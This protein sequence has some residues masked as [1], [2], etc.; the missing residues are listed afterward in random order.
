MK[1]NHSPGNTALRVGLVLITVSLFGALFSGTYQA[2]DF[3][4]MSGMFYMVNGMADASVLSNVLG[5]A[6]GFVFP[7]LTL[8]ALL[9]S[10]ITK[11]SGALL[12]IAAFSVLAGHL[13]YAVSQLLPGAYF[14][15]ANWLHLLLGPYSLTDPM[16]VNAPAIIERLSGYVGMVG[17]VVVLV[18][19]LISQS[20]RK[21]RVQDL[22]PVTSGSAGIT[23][24][25]T[26][27]GQPIYGNAPT[28]N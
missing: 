18:A 9:V 2:R 7:G 20:S 15:T 22:T 4:T 13:V 8:L 23:G 14:G 16:F 25:D 10:L 11:R 3:R 17:A 27:T 1:A 12:A 28:Q 19:L 24:Y 5:L 6:S 21:R 26:N